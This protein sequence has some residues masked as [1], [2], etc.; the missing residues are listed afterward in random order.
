MAPDGTAGLM[1]SAPLVST[2]DARD[3]GVEKGVCYT[4]KGLFVKCSGQPRKP[5]YSRAC[6]CT[7]GDTS[8]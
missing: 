3:D 2:K 4:A 7:A 5:F 6:A 8:V 1:F